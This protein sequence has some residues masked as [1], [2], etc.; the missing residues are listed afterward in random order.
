MS[1][2]PYLD[3]QAI[4]QSYSINELMDMTGLKFKKN[5]KSYRCECPIHQGGERSLVVSPDVKDDKGDLGVFFCHA[6]NQGGDRVTLLAHV[7]DSKPYAI[8]KELAERKGTAVDYQKT[9]V[10]I[11]PTIPEEKESITKGERGFQPLDYLQAVHPS[12]QA[13]GISPD[14]ARLL[15]IGFA[16]RG[17]HRGCVAFPVRTA[18]GIL[19]GYIGLDGQSVRLPPGWKL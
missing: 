9:T 15:G 6:S 11:V 17:Y 16:P 1:K 14:V 19:A 5:G 7:R 10:P 13:L 2:T 18:D 8:F 3:F 12:V 4:K